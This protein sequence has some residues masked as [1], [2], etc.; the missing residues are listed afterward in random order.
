MILSYPI[1][2]R[3]RRD[4]AVN[5]IRNW[6]QDDEKDVLY[7]VESEEEFSENEEEAEESC[8]QLEYGDWKLHKL[9]LGKL[10]LNV[11]NVDDN[12]DFITGREKVV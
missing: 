8:V 10:V 4:D 6:V 9:K 2:N 5:N 12:V 3:I 11:N 7:R 1:C